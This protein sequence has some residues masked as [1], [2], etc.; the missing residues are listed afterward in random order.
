MG[1]G[2]A[3]IPEPKKKRIL[4]MSGQNSYRLTALGDTYAV[5]RVYL[6]KEE[7]FTEANTGASG[8]RASDKYRRPRLLPT[9]PFEVEALSLKVDLDAASWVTDTLLLVVDELQVSGVET[10]KDLRAKALEHFE[11]RDSKLSKNQKYDSYTR[12]RFG[13]SYSE[14]VNQL[15]GQAIDRFKTA[16]DGILY[17]PEME[18]WRQPHLR[19]VVVGYEIAAEREVI[20][21]LIDLAD[22][23]HVHSQYLAALLLCFTQQ[24]LT[25]QSIELLLEAH[26]NKHPQALDALGR[27]LLA[28][29]D[30]VGAVQAALIARQG[31]YPEAKRTIELVQRALTMA[32]LETPSGVVP[33]F[34]AVLGVLDSNYLELARKQ[35]PEWFPSES[36]RTKAFFHR[37]AG[38]SRHV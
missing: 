24:G 12:E 3:G 19:D 34:A 9:S 13:K 26:E 35:F 38:G 14:L 10:V 33:A 4:Q 28:Q 32:V 11:G 1:C 30:Y 23:G 21:E 31:Q 37:L 22:C 7:H 15:R 2:V 36:D 27:L 25:K 5:R 20:A 8:S 6:N 18:S 16:F 17:V 29:D